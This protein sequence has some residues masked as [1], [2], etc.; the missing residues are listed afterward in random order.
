MM[1]S[2]AKFIFLLPLLSGAS[3]F[4]QVTAKQ[5]ETRAKLEK[6]IAANLH[7]VIGTQLEDDT[8]TVAVAIQ[9][10]ESKPPEKPPVK[11]PEVAD[12]PLGLDL[13]VIDVQGLMESYERELAETKAKY[14]DKKDA[15]KEPQFQISGIKISVG[16]DERYP[17]A[18]RN[19]F[20]GW[21]S[22]RV[23]SDYGSLAKTDVTTIFRTA[24]KAPPLE[25]ESLIDKVRKL[26][27]LLGLAI[28][29]AALLAGMLWIGVGLLR[30]ATARKKMVLEQGGEWAINGEALGA[31]SS[32][33][34]SA[35]KSVLPV[36]PVE[37]LPSNHDLE[38]Q[39]AKIAFVCMEL[40]EKVNELVRV[41]LDNGD[42]GI[43][44]TAL[45]VDAIITAR[46]K[47]LARAG[48]LP[49]LQIPLDPEV[50]QAREE[51]L[52][53]AFRE[54]AAMEIE[55]RL[56]KLEQI[57]W[58]LISVR[59]LG[60]QSLRRPFDFLAGMNTQEIQTVLSTQKTDAR[61]LAV[62]YMDS[63]V[64]TEFVNS[65]HE[66]ERETVIAG[67]LAYSQISQKTIWDMDTA[68]KVA[69]MTVAEP[70][71]ERVVNLFPRTLEVLQTLNSLDEI[72]I[73]R[74]IVPSLPDQGRTL[75][76]QYS[77]LA[78][79]D[80]WRPEYVRKLTSVATGDELTTL[81]R[82]VPQGKDRILSECPPK[83][84][85]IV[86][87]DLKMNTTFEDS[88]TNNRLDALRSKWNTI[89][90]SERISLARVIEMPPVGEGLT[91]VA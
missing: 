55:D 89:V 40:K 9:L 20:A 3:A 84:R 30:V 68:V 72:R 25:N 28:L 60:L 22:K 69:S 33:E 51:N 13:G 6:D 86:E 10:R 24:A 66:P 87:D 67:V 56:P 82:T 16:L 7:N 85:T 45:L 62:M 26:Q 63:E 65:L 81:I 15:S 59:T 36:Q 8:F 12:R 50:V 47:I 4:G 14:D 23:K 57:Y 74:R 46:E 88:V 39:I 79:V 11:K 32:A 91:N 70:N 48:A 2:Y 58:D 54:V 49:A 75:K 78:F 90:A 27:S 19:D 5:L 53:E 21:L 83:V 18:Y 77:T 42:E 35:E 38:L 76:T 61:A 52:A 34:D 31:G 43:I 1:K 71:K 64:K 41:W 29:A 80:S 44:K 17:E 37:A 73:L